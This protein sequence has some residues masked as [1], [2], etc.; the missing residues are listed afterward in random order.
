VATLTKDLVDVPAD[1]VEA[2]QKVWFAGLGALAMAQG[3]GGKLFS[4]L[5][6][7][8]Q[9]IDEAGGASVAALRKQA[10]GAPG[11]LWKKV[12]TLVDAQVTGALHGLD[13]PTK[14]ELAA[15]TRKIEHLTASIE[16]LKIRR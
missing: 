15:L 4:L 14:G 5:V 7:R 10:T 9:E 11:D 12:Q 2:A 1:V 8:G 13:V 16:G 6:E 3:E